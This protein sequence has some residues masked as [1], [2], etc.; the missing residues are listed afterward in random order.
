MA[1]C[2]ANS[3]LVAKQTIFME[4][5]SASTNALNWFEIPVSD[6]NRARKF[7]ET[8]FDVAL[9][10]VDMMGME[11]AMFP[12]QPP[13]S[14]G[15]L[16]RSPQHIPSTTGCVIYLNGNPDLG[17]ILERIP[18]AGGTITLPKT[19]INEETGYMA[20]FLDTEGNSMGLHSIT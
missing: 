14:G 8:V 7:Y 15:S 17:R 19:H 6:M 2:R 3:I 1:R 9:T 10:Q 5:L 11:M 18:A 12:S 20:F 16:V 4:K 13:H